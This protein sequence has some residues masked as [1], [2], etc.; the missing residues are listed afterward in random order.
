[1]VTLAWSTDSSDGLVT[2]PCEFCLAFHKLSLIHLWTD[3]PPYEKSNT[4][5]AFPSRT[6]G[7]CP[8]LRTRVRGTR[9]TVLRMST[10]FRPGRSMV[11]PL[12]DVPTRTISLRPH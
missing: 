9:R 5:A 7:F 2:T 12:G 4:V 6:V 1:M 11:S 10:H 3:M 8:A